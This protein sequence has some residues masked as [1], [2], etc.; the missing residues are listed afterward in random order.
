MQASEQALAARSQGFRW[1]PWF[2]LAFVA[3]L[4]TVGPAEAV[5]SLGSLLA[6]AVLLWQRFQ[7][8]T[9]LLSR[10]AWALCTALFFAYWLPQLL[11]AFDSLDGARTWKG[12]ATDLRYLPFLWLVAMAMAT[13]RGRRVVTLGLA[14]IVLFW[15]ADGLVQAAT[16]WSLGI[17]LHPHDPATADRLSG[18]FG[19]GNLKLGLILC[20]LSP[21]ALEA[22]RERTG[23]VGWLVGAVGIGVVILLAGARAAWL[24]YTIVLVVSGWRA[25]RSK[26]QLAAVIGLGLAVAVAGYAA[27]PNFRGRIQRSV[28]LITQHDA[29]V[30]S[31][32]RMSLWR[33]AAAMAL[34]HPIN[35]VGVRS[36]RIAYPRYAAPGD[37]FISKGE[38]ALHAHQIVLE[39]LTET[40]VL[41]LLLWIAGAVLAWRAWWW[42][43][44]AARERARVPALALGVTVFPLNTH[45]AFYSNFWG[46]VF[47]LLL[48]LFA[49]SLLSGDENERAAGRLP[50]GDGDV[51]APAA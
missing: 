33:A 24:M 19:A 38:T 11:S 2:V 28:V 46:G 4:P 23:A 22:L 16:G 29:D 26:A 42:A 5:L 6:M 40:G 34:D 18:I 13:A 12:V 47:L 51:R 50:A 41:G 37:F 21:Y 15:T 25:L 30:A 7:G 43:P 45:L 48:A 27:S 8:G 44:P 10:E 9:R 3:L 17:P 32:G 35:G 36:F 20:S 1:A 31:S 14:V 49:G 39:I